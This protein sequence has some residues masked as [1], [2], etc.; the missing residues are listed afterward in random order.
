MSGSK[1]LD[2]SS[3]RAA[4]EA[5]QHRANGHGD[6]PLGLTVHSLPSPACALD[7][8]A[9]RTGTGRWKMLV[10][11]PVCAAPVVASYLTFYVLRPEGRRNFGELIE[12]QRPLPDQTVVSLSGQASSL[13]A[14][15]GQWLL[16]SVANGAC[17]DVCRRHL[18]LQRQLREGL[19]KDKDRVDWVWLIPD[20]A[21]VP[22]QLLP[23]LKEA[24]VLRADRQAL[25][26]WLA[27]AGGHQLAEHLYLV[28]PLGNWMMRFPADL[29][30]ASVAKV[31]RDLERLLRASSSWDQAGRVPLTER[32]GENAK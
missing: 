30:L 11:L 1:L 9:R 16:L 28:D 10:V 4:P 5:S 14:L 15:K 23:A 31:K 2:D 12:P 19:G 24:T 27:P 29:D 26:S 8:H 3:T 13:K 7:A 22:E 32:G 25:S 21:P 17:D 20:A 18:Y 6:Q